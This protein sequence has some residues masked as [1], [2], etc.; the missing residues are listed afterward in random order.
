MSE[1]ELIEQRLVKIQNL[2]AQNINPFANDFVCS[3]NIQSIISDCSKLT[4]EDLEATELTLNIA[5][6]VMAIN[7][8]GKIGFIRIQDGTSDQ[9]LQLFLSK[10]ILSEKDFLQF[11][12]LDIGDIIGVSGSLMRTKTSELTIRAT[13]FRILTKSIRPLPDKFHG[14]TDVE[15]RYRQRY[16]DLTMN[17]ESRKIF[18]TR[19]KVISSIRNY[20]DASEFVEVETPMMHPIAGGAAAKPFITHHN[21]L[22]RDLFLRIAPELYLKRLLV[23]GLD[24]VYEINRN[25]RN[26]GLSTFHNP[27][28][29]TLEFYC[30]YWDYNK[31]MSVCENIIHRVMEDCDIND[32]VFFGEHELFFQGAFQK[33]TMLEAINHHGGPNVVELR[34]EKRVENVVKDLELYQDGMNYGQMIVALFEHYAEPNLIQP[35]FIYD[36]PVEVSPLA[37]QK[38]DDPRFVERFELFVAGHELANAFSELNNPIEQRKRFE[39]QLAA[40]ESGDEEAH[41]MDEDYVKALEYGM[42]PAGGF[43]MGID[44]LVMLLTNS[45]S[46]KDVILFPQLKSK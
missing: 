25:F 12:Q 42:P 8:F 5:G 10:K 21:K 11:K 28:F 44:R 3:S 43:G 13:G 17:M 19:A 9:R 18:K 41:Q 20:L 33:M 32:P 6:R 37:R 31:L 14:L 27:E 39:E 30:A 7:S 1:Q 34:D 45:Q 4:S 16:L 22:D 46:I 24:R 29:T 23:G 2:R 40:R 35:T 38:D 36:F 15:A 26:E